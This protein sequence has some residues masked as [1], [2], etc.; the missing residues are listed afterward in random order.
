MQLRGYILYETTY[1]LN[2]TENIHLI[3]E[4]NKFEKLLCPAGRAGEPPVPTPPPQGNRDRAPHLLPAI[5][6]LGM[7]T[8][9]PIM[10]VITMIICI[11]LSEFDSMSNIWSHCF[12][13][14]IIIITMGQ[15]G[16]QRC[17]RIIRSIVAFHDIESCLV[18]S[19]FSLRSAQ[20]EVFDVTTDPVPPPKT[21]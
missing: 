18:M 17:R 20:H 19:D 11:F 8:I 15:S 1:Y 21:A 5:P 4:A 3:S 10:F 16:S 7:I 9:V 14:T 13:T 6:Q 2:H 12:P